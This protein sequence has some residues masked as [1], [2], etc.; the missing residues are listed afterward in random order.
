MPKKQRNKLGHFI[1]SNMM[2][3]KSN[4]VK[5]S[6]THKFSTLVMAIFAIFVASPQLT[7]LFKMEKN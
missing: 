2:A 6:S 4:Y 1:S 5:D 7:I 3:Q